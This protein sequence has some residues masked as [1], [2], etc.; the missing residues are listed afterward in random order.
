MRFFKRLLAAFGC[1]ALL[2]SLCSCTDWEEGSYVAYI[3]PDGLELITAERIENGECAAILEAIGKSEDEAISTLSE[4]R[5][6]FS[7]FMPRTE[8]GETT[9]PVEMALTVDTNMASR[10]IFNFSALSSEDWSYIFEQSKKAITE[11]EDA[12]FT[13]FSEVVYHGNRS[14]RTEYTVTENG[15]T[16]NFIV[17]ETVYNG[18]VYTFFCVTDL[19]IDDEIRSFAEQFYGN[20]TFT[21]ELQPKYKF[22]RDMTF[23]DTFKRFLQENWLTMLIVAVATVGGSITALFLF[24]RHKKKHKD[25]P[26]KIVRA[27]YLK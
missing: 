6:F 22:I 13:D 8:N 12:T 7:A 5:L 3:C 27:D 9:Y 17:Y 16:A 11:D 24:A 23:A 14:I 20:I 26:K 21:K 18:F 4:R 19:P 10:N 15:A 2:L 1:A 25:D